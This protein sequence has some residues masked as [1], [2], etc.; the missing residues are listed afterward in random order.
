[1]QSQNKPYK[2]LETKSITSNAMQ[3]RQDVRQTAEHREWS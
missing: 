3:Y 2:K 1:M